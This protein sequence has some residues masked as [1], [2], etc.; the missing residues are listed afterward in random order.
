[1]NQ[2]EGFRSTVIISKKDRPRLAYALQS[3]LREI[4]LREDI[5]QANASIYRSKLFN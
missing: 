1:M 3:A 2:I 4:Y 5:I